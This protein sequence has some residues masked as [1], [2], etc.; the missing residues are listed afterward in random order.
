MGKKMSCSSNLKRHIGSCINTLVSSTNSFLD[1]LG[2]GLRA[3]PAGAGADAALWT[4]SVLT[5]LGLRF[6][7]LAGTGSGCNSCLGRSVPAV[8]LAG[9]ATGSCLLAG[10]AKGRT[11]VSR[12]SLESKAARLVGAGGKG[13]D[14]KLNE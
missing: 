5:G 8:F 14:F 4:A 9:L 12:A 1:P 10:L 11:G 3:L 6:S 13:M 7:I 2:L